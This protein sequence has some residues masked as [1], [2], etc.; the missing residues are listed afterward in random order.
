MYEPVHGSAFDL[1]GR[2]VANPIGAVLSL[3]MMVDDL[4]HPAA[5]RRVRDAVED[6][7]ARGILTRDVGGTASTDDVAEALVAS[8]AGRTLE[9]TP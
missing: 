6:V 1:V 5:A 8:V 9:V 2:N 7:C 4:G 3:A